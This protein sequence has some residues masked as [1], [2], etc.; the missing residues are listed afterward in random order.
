MRKKYVQ[1]QLKSEV[2]K[3]AKLL[4]V[5]PATKAAHEWSCSAKKKHI[6]E[7]FPRHTRIGNRVNHCI[8]LHMHCEKPYQLNMTVVTKD[9]IGDNQA[10]L[11]A[12]EKF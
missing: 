3:S 7:T 4:L 6:H 2:V 8:M 5:M 9:F 12:F 11:R 10:R 1:E